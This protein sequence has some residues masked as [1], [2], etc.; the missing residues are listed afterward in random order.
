MFFITGRRQTELDHAKTLIGRNVTT[1]QGDVANLSDIDR[2][3]KIVAAEKGVLHIVVANAGMMEHQTIDK[4]TPEH[5]DKTFNLNV[6]GTYFTVSKALPLMKNGGSIVLV[7]SVV[8]VKG[9]PAHGAYAASKA[10]IRSFTRTWANELKGSNIRVNSLSPGPIDTPIF[11]AVFKTKQEAD[12]GRAA[13]ASKTLM[14]RMGTTKEMASA[15][16]FLA[17]DEGVFC[18][19]SD[20]MADGGLSEA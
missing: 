8:H 4:A 7:S 18:N 3:Y 6:R 1:V 11:D 16:V 12:G 13:Y 20:L 15:I 14:G 5:F 17:S 2:L 19:G 10:A 9:F